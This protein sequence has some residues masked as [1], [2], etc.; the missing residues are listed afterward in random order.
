VTSTPPPADQIAATTAA[1]GALGGAASRS[2]GGTAGGTPGGGS[3]G[4]G[5]GQGT[6][7]PAATG[8]SSAP[9]LPACMIGT[10]SAPMSREFGNLA[11]ER[12][13][14]GTVR[15]ATG[16]LAVTFTS[17][18]HWTFTYRQVKL[19][20]AA[21]WVGVDG[22]VNGTWEL[23]GNSLRSTA[24]SMAVRATMHLGEVS[25]GIVPSAVTD[26][27]RALPPNQVFVNCTGTG[28]Q[29]LLP[30]AQ[31]GGTVTFDHS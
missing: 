1:S 12:R 28:L 29:F 30:T 24:G 16:G 18:R 26:L 2:P 21:G 25:V 4:G 17:D 23:A 13:S 20:L 14:N 15:S 5:S 9:D 11:L 8:S 10:W 19:Q 31:G 6:P 27:V 3:D 7:R 22:P